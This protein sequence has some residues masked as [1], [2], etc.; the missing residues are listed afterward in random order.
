MKPLFYFYAAALFF[1]SGCTKDDDQLSPDPFF[2]SQETFKA[3]LFIEVY[4]PDGFRVSNAKVM[5]GAQEGYTDASGLLYL[6]EATVGATA[7]LT[8][9]KEG[10]FHASR[11]F[12]A[13]P[14]KAQTI[15]IILL[16]NS[17]IAFF[18]AGDGAVLPLE[19]QATIRFPKGGYVLDDGDSYEGVV[20]IS[21]KV[22]AA[23]DP[24]LSLMMPGDLVG[25]NS[26]GQLGALGSLGMITVEM[27]TPNGDKLK[28]KDDV[29][30]TMEMIIPAAMTDKAP[31]TIPMWYFD[32]YAGVWKEEGVATRAGDRYIGQVRHFSFWNYDAWFSTIEWGA[33]FAYEDGS[34]ASQVKVCI[35]IDNLG[36][37]K[38]EYTDAEGSVHGL[39]AKDERLGLTVLGACNEV[40]YESVL[41]PYSGNALIGPVS[42]A[43]SGA[44]SRISG[45]VVDCLHK[46]LSDGF[47]K[48]STGRESY[49]LI[50]DPQTG[51]FESIVSSCI[52][53]NITVFSYN[54]TDMTFSDVRTVPY[55]PV[56]NTDTLLTCSTLEEY[57]IIEIEGFPNPIYF[58]SLEFRIFEEY[59]SIRAEDIS[60]SMF[61]VWFEGSTI[62]SYYAMKDSGVRGVIDSIQFQSLGPLR[63]TIDAYGAAGEYVTGK[64][65]GK[66][67]TSEFGPIP[68]YQMTGRF[69]VRRDQ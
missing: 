54:N 27:K 51:A 65:Q 19:D 56:I 8:V 43:N 28:F 55:S 57:A 10:Y 14:G 42:I 5:L 7:Y 23:D 32:E 58:D 48:V 25:V 39:V 35:T 36:T 53:G 59:T 11:R 16:S 50:P 18:N 34:P 49:Y 22:I 29:E 4:T 33:S 47:V 15:R 66:V 62:G 69:S 44:L 63:I 38:C 60:G 20:V 30:A 13:M 21:A 2:P 9:E 37:S 68:E 6:K 17:R 67:H 41:G 26:A 1:L 24:D 3:P 31:S 64:V 52:G 61:G 12:Y 45:Y 40:L 46:P